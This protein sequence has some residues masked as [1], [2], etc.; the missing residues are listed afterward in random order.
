MALDKL[1]I[2]GVEADPRDVLPSSTLVNSKGKATEAI[3]TASGSIDDDS[4]TNTP[5]E[6]EHSKTTTP[7]DGGGE[8]QVDSDTGAGKKGNKGKGKWGA[9]GT[10]TNNA[11]NKVN[12]TSTTVTTAN[13]SLNNSADLESQQNVSAQNVNVQETA[14]PA[15]KEGTP[16]WGQVNPAQEEPKWEE[17]SSWN[18]ESANAKAGWGT[19]PWN[20]KT[21]DTQKT[22]WG[23]PE[24]VGPFEMN[25]DFKLIVITEL[26]N[27]QYRFYCLH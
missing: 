23:K 14:K 20:A 12:T 8:S 7:K 13:R 9:K 1:L 24:S 21:S 3:S 17:K 5:K 25:M 4:K 19:A 22:G 26:L 18:Q 15:A 11:A 10:E 6:R 27:L 2:E 16:G